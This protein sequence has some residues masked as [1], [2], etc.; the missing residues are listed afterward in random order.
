MLIKIKCHCNKKKSL[1]LLFI[2]PESNGSCLVNN[3]RHMENGTTWEKDPCTIC[4]CL[5]GYLFCKASTSENCTENP[6]IYF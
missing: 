3:S 5:N 1:L 6:G 2:V 4:S